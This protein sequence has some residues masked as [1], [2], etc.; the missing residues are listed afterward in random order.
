MCVM[1]HTTRLTWG[2][3]R[4]LHPSFSLFIRR[5]S[6]LRN[7]HHHSGKI[8]CVQGVIEI[9]HSLQEERWSLCDKAKIGIRSQGSVWLEPATTT[10]GVQLSHPQK[11]TTPS[12]LTAPQCSHSFSCLDTTQAWLWTW[13]WLL[14]CIPRCLNNKW[15]GLL[16]EGGNFWAKVLSPLLAG[17]CCTNWNQTGWGK[18]IYREHKCMY[19]E[20]GTGNDSGR[21]DG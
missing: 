16:S 19:S 3:V 5:L 20:Q 9:T 8:G 10:T 17:H 4:V 14:I 1:V 15:L 12:V 18:W 21:R 11:T 7:E 13:I 6:H 2:E